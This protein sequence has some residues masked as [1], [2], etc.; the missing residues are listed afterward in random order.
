VVFGHIRFYSLQRFVDLK[1]RE[2]F[3]LLPLVFAVF[4]MGIYP[5]IFLDV[6]DISMNNYIHL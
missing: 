6:V 1:R 5:N 3:L 4:F 2:F